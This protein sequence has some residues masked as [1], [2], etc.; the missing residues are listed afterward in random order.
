MQRRPFQFLWW[1][2][3]LIAATLAC[4]FFSEVG[5]RARDI[6]EDVQSAATDVQTG[7]DLLSTGQAVATQF[8]GNEI[9]QTARAVATEQGS[10]FLATAQAVA[11]EH[12]PSL[13]E[14]ARAFATEHGPSLEETARAFATGEAPGLVETARALLGDIT[15]PTNTPPE[16]IPIVQAENEHFFASQSFVSYSSSLGF[17]QVIEFYESEMPA[18]GWSKVSE[19]SFTSENIA[20]LVF[21]K[22]DRRASITISIIPDNNLTLIIIGISP[23]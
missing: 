7:R 13:E 1:I 21:E 22:S 9:M 2:S 3:F 18:N 6:Q 16:D 17:T 12:G 15:S 5:Q 11:T 4:T 8:L 19:A 14:T 23:I 20:T 10:Q